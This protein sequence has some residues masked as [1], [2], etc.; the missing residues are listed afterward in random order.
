[1]NGLLYT[2]GGSRGN[3]GNAAAGC[4]LFDSN[5]KLLN[6]D[7]KY[8][9]ILTNNQ[10]EYQALMLGLKLATK[11]GINNLAVHL[12]SELVVKQLNGEYKI[13]DE[14][15]QNLKP[16]ID[17]LVK[18]FSKISFTHVLRVNNSYADKLVNLILDARE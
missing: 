18:N 6:F 15:I 12:D 1:M 7:A 4:L 9:G 17:K 16:Q 2:D 10:A 5:H 11:S 3:P 14:K 8:L 13:K